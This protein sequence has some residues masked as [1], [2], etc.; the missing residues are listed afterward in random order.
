AR[1]RAVEVLLYAA[2]RRQ[3]D[4]ALAMGVSAGETPVVVLVDG[5]ASPDGGRGTRSDRE[6]AAADG[7]ATLLDP[8]ETVGEYDPETVRAFFA[9]S[10]R[11]LAATDGTV[12]DV[13]HER[14]ALLDVE[15]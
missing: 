7:V 13:V 15:K 9:I 4:D 5:R 10:D 11:E 8:T 12:V 1:D 6:D 14:V 3:I 2:G